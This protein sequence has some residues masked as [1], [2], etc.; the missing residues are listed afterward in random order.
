MS[1]SRSNNN[2][3]ERGDDKK[4]ASDDYPRKDGGKVEKKRPKLTGSGIPE[5]ARLFQ[6][7]AGRDLPSI[8]ERSNG[9]ISEFRATC[10]IFGV[11]L[12]Q[13]NLSRF[14][15]NQRPKGKGQ[16]SEPYLN[17]EECRKHNLTIL[18]P[19]ATVGQHQKLLSGSI[20]SS[21]RPPPSRESPASNR[22]SAPSLP[23]SHHPGGVGKYK[24]SPHLASSSQNPL[25]SGLHSTRDPSPMDEDE[26]FHAPLDSELNRLK[27][28]L[29]PATEHSKVKGKE[30][31]PEYE[32]VF[33]R[34]RVDDPCS[35]EELVGPARNRAIIQRQ[36]G[37]LSPRTLVTVRPK[38]P[39]PSSS[40]DVPPSPCLDGTSDPCSSNTNL[41]EKEPG[42]NRYNIDA[43]LSLV[44]RLKNLD[45]DVVINESKLK[46]N[47]TYRNEKLA[48]FTALVDDRRAFLY[49]T[50]SGVREML[51]DATSELQTLLRIRQPTIRHLDN[52]HAYSD[53]SL[54]SIRR[55][56]TS[57][58]VE[59]QLKVK[60]ARAKQLTL[61]QSPP[62]PPP[63]PPALVLATPRRLSANVR[64]PPNHPLT[65]KKEALAI[66]LDGE[67]LTDTTTASVGSVSD[68]DNPPDP[69]QVIPS[70]SSS[71]RKAPRHSVS[72][73]RAP[74]VDESK[75][76]RF[77]VE[78]I[79]KR[80]TLLQYRHRRSGPS[81]PARPSLAVSKKDDAL[82]LL[83]KTSARV[84]QTSSLAVIPPTDT[85]SS[86]LETSV[87]VKH[88]L[89]EQTTPLL[90]PSTAPDA[91]L[92]VRED[93]AARVDEENP[94][95]NG[96]PIE[97]D[98]D[99]SPSSTPPCSPYPTLRDLVLDSSS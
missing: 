76:R 24:G 62:P 7:K 2:W 20:T 54:V 83:A 44:E 80:L 61:L 81:S 70:A 75:S 23:K 95:N 77:D 57:V 94:V 10:A 41:R 5:N 50:I 78:G 90:V 68:D 32:E 39:S 38:A 1:S 53:A 11:P 96:E 4:R 35:Y 26:V 72:R 29:E 22:A 30:P 3:R 69:R 45:V 42:S 56:W 9:I 59:S 15:R 36:Q 49:K 37:C 63:P 51:V 85:S 65:P 67:S 82:A 73:P 64:L 33:L 97:V 16:L 48:S 27:A 84:G 99:D 93:P 21:S 40:R 6:I 98:D 52:E 89:T 79:T 18:D 14:I 86:K 58:L 71:R 87:L 25:P 46:S 17:D 12:C 43:V 28:G 55:D 34:P 19:R 60:E 13:E 91:A 31:L 74:G 88:T 92:I 47:P 66:D 8:T